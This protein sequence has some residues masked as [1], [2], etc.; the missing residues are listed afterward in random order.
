MNNLFIVWSRIPRGL[1]VTD[2]LIY[3]YNK[4]SNDLSRYVL[5][6]RFALNASYITTHAF[7]EVILMFEIL[8]FTYLEY[9]FVYRNSIK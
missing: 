1:Q 2:Q 8:Y 9:I 5:S 6:L 4:Q 7:S 3:I